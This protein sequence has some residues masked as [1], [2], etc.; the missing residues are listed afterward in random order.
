MHEQGSAIDFANTRGAYA[1]LKRN[2]AR[3]GLI[4]YPREAWHYS[5]NGR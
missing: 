1:W 4:N 5:T 2:A 3:F